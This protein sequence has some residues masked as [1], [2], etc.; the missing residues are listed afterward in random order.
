MSTNTK[1]PRRSVKSMVQSI[2]KRIQTYELELQHQENAE[3]ILQA[4]I[5]VLKEVLANSFPEIVRERP[6]IMLDPDA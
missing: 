4:K 3:M 1:R 6:R 5:G 2:E